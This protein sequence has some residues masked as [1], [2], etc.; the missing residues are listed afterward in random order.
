MIYRLY[1]IVLICLLSTVQ[2]FA[3]YQNKFIRL[4]V[5]NGLSQ[6]WVRCIYQDHFGFLWF[7]TKDGLNKFNGS[8]FVIYRASDT[9]SFRISNS[10]INDIHEEPNGNLWIAT[11]RGLS[12]YQR[13][14]DNFINFGPLSNYAITCI[15]KTHNGDFWFGSES[16][17]FLYHTSTKSLRRFLHVEE[18][19][20]SLN[21]NNILSLHEDA[22]NRVWVGT[23]RGLNIFDKSDS[24]F[25]Q[26][27]SGNNNPC[28][29]N[30]EVHAIVEDKSGNIYTGTSGGGLDIF[31]INDDF[32][33]CSPKRILTG[34][35]V[36]LYIDNRN[37]LLVGRGGGGGFS[38]VPLNNL[39]WPYT[40]F[41]SF[42]N[43]PGNEHSISDNSIESFFE[44]ENG[45]IW[46]GT[47]GNGANLYSN[48]N[49]KF[50]QESHL[51]DYNNLL[52]NKLVNS[53][54]EEE[55]YLWIGTE[56][57]LNRID[58]ETGAV[59]LFKHDDH[60]PGSIGANAVYAIFKD[61][62]GNL[63]IGTWNG[64]LHIYNYQKENFT[65]F[66]ND[67]KNPRSISSNR[68]FKI[69]QDKEGRLWLGTI[70][71]GLNLYDY[72][73]NTFKR[74]AMPDAEYSI[75]YVNDIIETPDSLIWF[76]G[77]S[78]LN[79]L[80]PKDQTIKQ[81]YYIPEDEHSLSDGDI[82]VLY[83]DSKSN[84]WIGCEGGLNLFNRGQGSFSRFNT[85]NGLANNFIKS[86]LE[87]DRG[88][89][90]LSSNYGL[91]KFI[92]AIN[93][94]E[95]PV[96]INY[97]TDD[98]LNSKEYIKRSGYRNKR[99]ALF[100]GG[101]NGYTYFDPDSIYGSIKTL[102]VILT[103]LLVFNNKVIPGKDNPILPK[104][105][106]LLDKLNLTH[107]QSVFTIKYTSLNYLKPDK[108]RY[109]YIL[110]GFDG[111]WN[112]VGNRKFAT[113]TN[114]DA[115]DYVFKVK[116]SLNDT[117]WSDHIA[118]IPI[119][120]SPFW[121][122]TI[123]FRVLLGILF[124]TMILFFNYIR[125]YRL[126][127][128]HEEL[129]K[130][131]EIRTSELMESNRFLEESKEEITIQNEELSKH[132]NEL[133]RL[134]RERTKDLEAALQ[135]ANDSDNL[136]SA[137]LENISH[138]I[139][140]PM[141][142]ILGFTT[143]L[144]D[145][146]LSEESKKHYLKIIYSNSKSLLVLLNDVIDQSLINSNQVKLVPEKFNVCELLKDL[147]DTF[148]INNPKQL[149]IRFDDDQ[150]GKPLYIKADKIRLKQCLTNLI[151]NAYKFTHKGFIYFGY[152][153]VENQ[154]IFR[155][156][157]SGIGIAYD[158]QDK[159]YKQ[160]YKVELESE[161]VYRGA[162]LGLSIT[163]DLVELMNGELWH[164][165]I[166]GKGSTFY[167]SLPYSDEN[168]QP[169]T[170]WSKPITIDLGDYTFLVAE[171]ENINY[172]LVKEILLPTRAKI[173]RASNGSEAVFFVQ[174]H[175]TDNKLVI[176]M[177][178]KMPVMSGYQ[179]YAQIKQ[180]NPEIPVIAVTA[181]ATKPDI[182]TIEG[183]DFN[184]YVLK[185]FN[186]RELLNAI[187]KVLPSI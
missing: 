128:K 184:A 186:G 34:N 113:Y 33:S 58:K 152:N 132:R 74:F 86:I 177:D 92:G 79:V 30:L 153:V 161:K 5:E 62:F 17:L 173:V 99:G 109:A 133:E 61:S 165:S 20:E 120:I 80:N 77:F 106:Y 126:R 136:K 25:R 56:N 26:L 150:N 9:S 10:T 134:V 170:A 52:V 95:K 97:N 174:E 147:E 18:V 149:I 71:G 48:R 94:P 39:A 14:Y 187:Q 102:D 23:Q 157:D 75:D 144:N 180:I 108:D 142:A 13:D 115:G 154:I 166:K 158:Q 179:A 172:L 160:F 111:H 143:F 110:E 59:R 11:D 104:E 105:I 81:Y 69:F 46:I 181:Y 12:I 70:G 125:T 3:D 16:G 47:Y 72:K 118:S 89:L 32:N 42:K 112:Q 121:W 85:S 66:L 6:R 168:G 63:W 82:V 124:L 171:D 119:H 146:S 53:I 57:G 176:L 88:N 76:S 91:T 127:I 98:G 155:V 40:G 178:I 151:N 64:G 148:S 182:R 117:L 28:L 31:N 4:G 24:T 163:K 138:E 122:Q 162:G 164:E 90:W 43:I 156:S 123:G 54:F 116:V 49:Y 167:I 100:F 87:D 51:N 21:G 114:I 141:N 103:D 67:P 101:I 78:A 22:K 41:L 135:K 175:K 83:L 73:T 65:H 29:A 137:F 44:D 107:K 96:F 8:E 131:V 130:M 159:I 55:Q 1:I 2:S 84:L 7:G 145:D 183:Y 50:N 139:R 38:I 15:L 68:V 93:V 37:R 27:F 35:V 129:S 140:T 19:P 185:P 36:V 60:D 169:E 45:D